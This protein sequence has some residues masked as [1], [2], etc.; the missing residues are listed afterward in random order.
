[1]AIKLVLQMDVPHSTDLTPPS[2]A[3]L[4]DNPVMRNRRADHH[5]ALCDPQEKELHWKPSYAAYSGKS[6][7][8]SGCAT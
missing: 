3:E 4:V 2:P 7:P 5:I 6:T 1:M 8:G